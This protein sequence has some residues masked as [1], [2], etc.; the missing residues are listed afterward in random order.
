MPMILVFLMQEDKEILGRQALKIA[1]ILE[2]I[3]LIWLKR[4]EEYFIQL[5]SLVKG[6]WFDS[7]D[8]IGIIREAQSASKEALKGLGTD[9]SAELL[10]SSSGILYRFQ[11]ERS[12]LIEEI[13]DLRDSYA[14]AISRDGNSIR[15]ENESLYRA[16]K[17]VPM[18]QLLAILQ[19][20]RVTNYKE[21]EEKSEMKRSEVRKYTQDLVESSYASVDKSKRPH[22]ISFLSAP[23]N[24][25]SVSTYGTATQILL[26]DTNSLSA[27]HEN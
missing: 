9:L 2:E 13:N 19:D 4:I 26:A 11:S 15:Q 5:E 25:R 12:T 16:I 21:L 18:F 14:R 7:S 10:H 23:W 20:M 1:G 24:I 17:S 27:Q 22:E 3:Q 6:E 8:L